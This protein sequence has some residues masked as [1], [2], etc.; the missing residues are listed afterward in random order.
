M[1]SVVGEVLPTGNMVEV[2]FLSFP[3]FAIPFEGEVKMS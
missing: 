3:K 2:S 1:G